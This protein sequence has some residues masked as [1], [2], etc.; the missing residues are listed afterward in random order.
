MQFTYTVYK[1][2]I[3]VMLSTFEISPNN[4]SRFNP[5]DTENSVSQ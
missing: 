5:Y 1:Y 4:N 3:Q 2:I